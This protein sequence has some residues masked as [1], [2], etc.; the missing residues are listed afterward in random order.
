MDTPDKPS[1]AER[2]YAHSIAVLVIIFLAFIVCSSFREHALETATIALYILGW[3]SV[4]AIALVLGHT[5]LAHMTE[6]IGNLSARTAIQFGLPLFALT[7][8]YNYLFASSIHFTEH[9]LWNLVVAVVV[10]IALHG[11]PSP[12]APL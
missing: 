11:Q 12:H 7:S 2:G 6:R 3:V 1:R 10:S 8:S 5:T 9:L 4:A